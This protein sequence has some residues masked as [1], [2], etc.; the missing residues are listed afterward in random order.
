MAVGEG[1]AVA[2][3]VA[4]GMNVGKGVGSAGV[5]VGTGVAVLIAVGV[6]VGKGVS[7]RSTPSL[8]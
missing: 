8:R 5:I 2:V 6:D 4:A 3:F 1:V 7:A